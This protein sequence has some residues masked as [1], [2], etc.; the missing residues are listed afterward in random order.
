VQRSVPSKTHGSCRK[1]RPQD[2]AMRAF[3]ELQSDTMAG[4]RLFD[5]LFDDFQ[6]YTCREQQER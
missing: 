1:S 4:G 5:E 6:Y 2:L 3:P